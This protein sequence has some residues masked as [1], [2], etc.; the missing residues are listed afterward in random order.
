MS[1]G[2]T[3]VMGEQEMCWGDADLEVVAGLVPLNWFHV[4]S[5]H[6]LEHL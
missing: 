1:L 2:L 6:P 5:V 4:V 3:S